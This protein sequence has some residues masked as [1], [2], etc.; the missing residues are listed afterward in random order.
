MADVEDAPTARS[1]AICAL[2]QM[3][4]AG[5]ELRVSGHR[6][7][8]GESPIGVLSRIFVPGTGFASRAR[9][10]RAAEVDVLTR[11]SPS[12]ATFIASQRSWAGAVKDGPEG[13]SAASRGAASLAARNSPA[14]R[15][16]A[17]DQ[18]PHGARPVRTSAIHDPGVLPQASR[19]SAV[20]PK[21]P[22]PMARK[23]K[24]DH[25]DAERARFRHS[26]SGGGRVRCAG[27]GALKPRGLG[28]ARTARPGSRRVRL[29][30]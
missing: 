30:K 28:E 3:L 5:T 19:A 7:G 27:A 29:G 24:P 1:R 6:C 4:S 18:L 10:D 9:V 17:S 15:E 20:P 21:S 23:P 8:Q 25:I 22:G 14:T 26:L 11:R 12:G 16:I 2:W 13:P